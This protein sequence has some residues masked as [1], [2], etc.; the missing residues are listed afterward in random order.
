[1]HAADCPGCAEAREQAEE[2][3]LQIRAGRTFESAA[4]SVEDP[5]IRDKHRVFSA[6]LEQLPPP[7]AEAL[8]SLQPGES[9]EVVRT[10]FGFHIVQLVDRFEP[11]DLTLQDLGPQ[12][13]SVLQQ[14]MKLRAVQ[15]FCKEKEAQKGHVKYHVTFE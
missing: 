8:S 6:S 12:V 4:A 11:R 2:T 5:R 13:F 14:Q 15:E 7:L 9:S 3:Y 1:V 10:D